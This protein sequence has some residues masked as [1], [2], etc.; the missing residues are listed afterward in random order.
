MPAVPLSDLTFVVPCMG[1]LAHLARTL[2]RLLALAPA[3]VRVVDWNCPDGTAEWVAANHPS[4]AVLRV[5]DVA[6]FN[7]AAA[8]NAGAAHVQTPWICFVDADVLLDPR[9]GDVLRTLDPRAYFVADSAMPPL[10]GTVLCP[11]AAFQAV[12]GY[13][14]VMQGWGSEDTDFYRRLE[15]A[16]YARRVFDAALLEAIVH[17]DALRTLHYEEADPV[18]S[19]RLNAFY[20]HVKLDLMKLSGSPLSAP[21]RRALRARIEAQILAAEAGQGPAL[22]DL[23]VAHQAFSEEFELLAGLRYA[24]VPRKPR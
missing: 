20:M 8:R 22:L 9:F 5:R 21:A 13:D 14:E 11:R 1:R 15:L 18:R 7:L 17:E 24:L 4:C 2:P 10:R 3:Q 6:F 19:V 12:D 16:G 23:P